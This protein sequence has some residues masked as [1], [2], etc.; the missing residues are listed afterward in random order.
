MEKGRKIVLRPLKQQD[1][2]LVQ[3][4]YVDK[5]FRLAY[6]EYTS[7]DL[8]SIRKEIASQDKASLEDPRTEKI[9]YLV[10]RKSDLRPIGLAGLRHIDRHNGNVELLL[11]IGE[12]D[13]RLAGYGIDILIVL[14]DI[15]FYRLGL[16]KAYLNIYDNHDLG[17]R[18]AISFGFITEGKLR[19]QV[20]VEGKYIDLWVL[21]LL[22][23]EYEALS[24]VPK[25]KNRYTKK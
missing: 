15:V 14:L 12:K 19:K 5:D 20:F 11:G 9:I 8:E 10:Q 24:I 4:W 18:S 16:E 13:M 17:L 25:W 22:K 21:G 7:V 2:E 6:D 1:A 23:A 3:K